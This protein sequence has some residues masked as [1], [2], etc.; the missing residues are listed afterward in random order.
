MVEG[1]SERW[2]AIRAGSVGTS[3]RPK[4][5]VNEVGSSWSGSVANY[6]RI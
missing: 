6:A 4:L 2:A 3:G 5:L 1:A